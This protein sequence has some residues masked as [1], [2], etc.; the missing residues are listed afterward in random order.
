[1][2]Q[3]S[4]RAPRNGPL[5]PSTNNTPALAR[6]D[7][8]RGESGAAATG[9][10]WGCGHENMPYGLTYL[11]WHRRVEYTSSCMVHFGSEGPVKIGEI[12]QELEVLP[13]EPVIVPKPESETTAPETVSETRG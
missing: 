4:L 13:E 7:N 3:G 12:I 5:G 8:P 11:R 10:P 1:M 9:P 6:A 2:H